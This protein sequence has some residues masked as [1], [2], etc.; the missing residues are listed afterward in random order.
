MR[1]LG[2]LIVNEYVKNLMKISTII[3][4]AAVVLTAVGYNGIRYIQE[5]DRQKWSTSNI[6]YQSYDEE[7]SWAKSTKHEGWKLRVE[8]LTFLKENNIIQD[9]RHDDYWMHSAVHD[10]FEQKAMAKELL[11]EGKTA[12]AENAQKHADELGEAIKNK[13]WKAYNKINAGI[14]EYSLKNY[15]KLNLSEK[16][17]IWD[18][19]EH[20]EIGLWGAKYQLENEIAPFQ[21]NWK[22]V[23][24][25]NVRS[26]KHELLRLKSVSSAEQDQSAIADTEDALLIGEYR[27]ENNIKVNTSKSDGVMNDSHYE[28]GLSFWDVFTSSALGINVISVLIIIIAGS[29]I[30]S[31]FASGTIK[32]LLVNPVKRYKIFLAKYISVLSFAALM[33]IIYY[34]FNMVLSGIMFGFGDFTAPYLYVSG[35]EVAEG[36]SFLFVASKYLVSSIGMICMAT[37]AFAVSSVARNSALSIGLGVGLYLSGY[38]AVAL[39]SDMGLD[40]GRYIIFSNLELNAII[41]GISLYKGQTLPFA[42]AVI[43]A[44]MLVF[45]LTAW[46]G[47]IRRDVK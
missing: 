40:F 19:K 8:T 2:N 34:A 30:S 46:D 13:D 35:G 38:G 16:G 4:L 22:H 47:F 27:L 31:E 43:G 29:V 20:L 15:D 5:Q 17:G 26:D 36:S 23:L 33:L 45:L 10:V 14:L 9:Y 44:Y 39:M 32:Y 24:L 18:S 3:M 21:G 41:E 6:Y 37:L 12:L 1:K 42:L 25:S 28:N 7:I 11:N